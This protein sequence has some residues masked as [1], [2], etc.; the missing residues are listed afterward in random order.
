MIIHEYILVQELPWTEVLYAAFHTRQ[1]YLSSSIVFGT[2]PKVQ[3]ENIHKY[4][5]HLKLKCAE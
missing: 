4:Q 3:K 2:I 5:L 1:K